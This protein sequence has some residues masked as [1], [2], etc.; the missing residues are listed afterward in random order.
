[1]KTFLNFACVFC[2]MIAVCSCGPSK[3]EKAK[4]AKEEQER[5]EALAK[6]KADSIAQAAEEER[7]VEEEQR[8]QE[9]ALAK[10]EEEEQ[11]R[12]EEE[13]AAKEQRAEALLNGYWSEHSSIEDAHTTDG[14]EPMLDTYKFD[15]N[16]H[17]MSNVWI[18]YTKR[19]TKLTWSYTYENSKIH[20]THK[21]GGGFVMS[22][23]VDNMTITN[24]AD[25]RVYR[26][27]SGY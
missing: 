20:A 13:K 16:T 4:Q 26:K 17:T 24:E 15:S 23:D 1:M 12:A 19:R 21:N 22:F 27:L 7:R 25:G 5:I 3:E 9:E 8:A 11:A 14:F 6:Q 2:A 10:Q 18:Y